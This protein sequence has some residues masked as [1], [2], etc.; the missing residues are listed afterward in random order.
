MIGRF[1]EGL[2]SNYEN[3]KYSALLS[4]CVVERVDVLHLC[5]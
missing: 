3:W 2:G 4:F 5:V 1:G